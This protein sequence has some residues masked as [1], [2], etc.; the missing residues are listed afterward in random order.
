MSGA[1][2]DPTPAF[3]AVLLDESD[4]DDAATLAAL[5]D[6]PAVSVVDRRAAQRADL[7][8]LRDGGAGEHGTG[9]GRW[10]YYPWRR[11]LVGVLDR[12]PFVRLRTD[13]NRNKITADEQVRLSAL[14][15][16][17]VGL[18]VGHAVAHTLALEGLCGE[19]RL[20]DFDE[21]EVSNLNRVPASLLDLGVNKAVVAARRIAEL[22]PYLATSVCTAGVTPENLDGFLDGLDVLV[23]ECDSLDVNADFVATV[24]K[25]LAD[26]GLVGSDLVLEVTEHAVVSESAALLTLRGLR[27]LGVSIAIDDF[28]TGYSSLAQLKALPVTIVKIDRSF[29]RELGDSTDD[30]PIVRSILGLARSFGLDVIAEGVE[31]EVARALLL[32][33]GC[34][35]AQ[36][37]LFSCPVPAESVSALLGLTAG[38]GRRSA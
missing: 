16:G 19:L 36:G 14:R 6:D 22:D 20:A 38:P 11:T 2:P 35:S 4:P 21:I 23:E 5:R 7:A 13:R 9:P 12:A 33:L 27:A 26:R 18:S 3:R 8:G 34:A 25:V 17:V 1:A 24:E 31:T 37:Y 28:G 32:E 15:V 30:V 29:V 10:A